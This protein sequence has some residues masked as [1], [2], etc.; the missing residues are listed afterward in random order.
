MSGRKSKEGRRLAATPRPAQSTHRDPRLL[1]GVAALAAVLIV[2]SIVGVSLISGNSRNVSLTSGA[3][4]PDAAAVAAEFRGV[5]QHGLVL[6]AANAPVTLVEYIDLQCPWCGKFERES[7]PT[8]VSQFVRTGKVRVEMRPVDFV[9]PDSVRGRNALFAAAAQNKAFQFTALLYANQGT[10]NTGWLTD[11]MVGAAARS[12][13]GVDVA[14]VVGAGASASLAARI[15]QQRVQEDVTGV[16]TFFVKRSGAAGSGQ[17]L[18][19]PGEAT[20]TAAL[21]N[22]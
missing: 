12:I 10:E 9:G 8:V 7:F 5:P 18:V 11:E 19:N 15:E 2:G 21:R 16:P 22:A 13:P 14:Q 20:L 6:G 1:L 4:L 3:K 17:R